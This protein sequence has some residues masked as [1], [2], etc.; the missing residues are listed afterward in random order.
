VLVALVIFV[1][2]RTLRAS[3]IP[4]LTIP[5]ALIGAFA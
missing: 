4:L 2:L 5:V 3:I 1:F